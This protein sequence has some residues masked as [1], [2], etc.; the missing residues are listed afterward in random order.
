MIIPTSATQ[1]IAERRCPEWAGRTL[2]EHLREAAASVPQALAVA[3]GQTRLSFA[4]L[5]ELTAHAA[6]GLRGLGVGPADV[7]TVMLPNWW[8]ANVVVQALYRLGAVPNPLVPIYRERELSFVLQQARPSVI[9]VPHVFRGTDY[10][11]LLRASLRLAGHEAR[12]VVVRAQGPLPPGCLTIESMLNGGSEHPAGRVGA[13]DA[14]DIALLLYTSGTTADPKGVLHTHNTLDFEIRSIV[15]LYGLRTGEAV[16][17]PSP[18]THITG[19]LFGILMPPMLR[20]PAVLLDLW[21]P[22]TAM[23]LVNEF[24]CRFTMGATPFLQGLVEEY[25]A[26]GTGSPMRVFACGG[27]PVP[28]ALVRSAT[29]AMKTTVVRVYGSSEFPTYCS[30]APSDTF[31]KLSSTEGKPIATARHRLEDVQDGVGELVAFGP[32]L[33]AGYSDPAHDADAFTADGY[34]R[35]GDLF[36]EDEDGYLTVRGRKKDIIIRRGENIS[37]REVED[38]LFEHPDIADVA[39][40]GLP[41]PVVGERAA[42]FVVLRP[43]AEPVTLPAIA[44]H[45][46]SKHIAKQKYPEQVIL[47][48]ALP[49]TPSGKVQKFILRSNMAAQA[50]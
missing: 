17:M 1:R 28:P 32:E 48:D 27:A 37:A 24:N 38:L 41:D 4:E 14:D 8:E 29:T 3:D 11:E 18:V 5:A 9:V 40:V 20:A 36:S 39:V 45:L 2:D 16:F 34:F 7:V 25:R 30:G 26:T 31:E 35:T 47:L 44:A 23:R 12:I 10:P 43:G 21:A 50:R 19:F 15:E 6:A 42:A 22:A 13:A 33:F 49:K 46:D